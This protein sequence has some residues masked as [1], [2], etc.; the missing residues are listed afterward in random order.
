MSAAAAF[1]ADPDRR[2]GRRFCS[3]FSSAALRSRST[4]RSRSGASRWGPA[5]SAR[6]FGRRR[7]SQQPARA[8]TPRCSVTAADWRA[9]GRVALRDDVSRSA[10]D[11]RATRPPTSGTCAEDPVGVAQGVG[12]RVRQLQGPC[13]QRVLSAMTTRGSVCHAVED[14]DG[15][16]RFHVDQ[17]G[18]EARSDSQFAPGVRV[19]E[20]VTP[21]LRDTSLLLAV[22]MA[23]AD[24]DA[25]FDRVQQLAASCTTIRIRCAA[26][27]PA[28][29]GCRS[30]PFRAGRRTGTLVVLRRGAGPTRGWAQPSA[31]G[32]ASTPASSAATDVLADA[33]GAGSGALPVV[34]MLA[35]LP[36]VVGRYRPSPRL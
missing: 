4:R 3:E 17:L 28:R 5:R 30:K 13:G 11:H 6:G 20:V 27:D 33:G 29:R 23:S 36:R 25:A 1:L 9:C 21:G 10:P 32:L 16:L 7:T 31:T 24:A 35:L 34:R 8:P 18:F 19:V 2:L 14:Q 12:S 15:A 22:R 26:P